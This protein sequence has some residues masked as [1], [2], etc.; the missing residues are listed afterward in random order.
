LKTQT[1]YWSCNGTNFKAIWPDVMDIFYHAATKYVQASADGLV[2]VAPVILPHGA[3][4]TAVKVYGNAAAEHI[5][6]ELNRS[7]LGVDSS[8]GIAWARVNTEDTSIA[9]ATIDNSAYNYGLLISTE[10]DEKFD[11][12]DVIYGARITYTI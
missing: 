9:N 12:G 6:W 4:I 3:V 8:A 10:V 11:T 5:E 7:P 2:L 1:S